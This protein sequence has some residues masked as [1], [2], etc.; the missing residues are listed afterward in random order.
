MLSSSKVSGSFRLCALAY[1][2]FEFTKLKFI[3]D[4]NFGI[5]FTDL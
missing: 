2:L 1:H 4:F 5:A 3:K